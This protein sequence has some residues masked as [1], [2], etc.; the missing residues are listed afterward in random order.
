M[1]QIAIKSMKSSTSLGIREM[2]TKNTMRYY[3]LPTRKATINTHTHTHTHT[4]I[5]THPLLST[6]TGEDVEKLEPSHIAVGNVKWY[7]CYGRVWQFP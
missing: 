4:H 6:S 2:Q 1:I 7:N 5:P 3:L